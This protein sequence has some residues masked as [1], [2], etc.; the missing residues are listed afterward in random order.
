V[1]TAVR[2]KATYMLMQEENLKDFELGATLYGGFNKQG[3]VRSFPSMSDRSPL[4]RKSLCQS[5][6]T[7]CLINWYVC[8][9]VYLVNF[10]VLNVI[11]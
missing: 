7:V 6:K 10:T 2:A 4:N 3:D 11:E 8:F 9:K 1:F 5:S